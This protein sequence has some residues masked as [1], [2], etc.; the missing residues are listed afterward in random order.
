MHEHPETVDRQPGGPVETEI[1]QLLASAIDCT[2][3]EVWNESSNH[4]V[5]PGS[6]SHF[7]VLVV[8][9]SFEGEKRLARHRR[10][11][12]VLATPLAGPVHALAI[13]AHTPAEWQARGGA[14]AIS[15]DCLGGSKNDA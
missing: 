13:E 2:H 8:S 3:L 10:I 9:P 1:R 11:H 4:S 5:P 12:R 14:V 6:E 7:R 15:P